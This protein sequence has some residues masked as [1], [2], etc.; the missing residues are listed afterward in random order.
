M[1]NLPRKEAL[2]MLLKIEKDFSYIN[3]EMNEIRKI[4]QYTDQDIRFIGEL[5]NG[6]I[7][8][9]I[10]LDYIISL[11]SSVKLK[12]ISPYVLNVLRIGVYQIIF[13]DKVPDSAAVNECVKL[14]KKSSVYK[15]ASFVNAVLRNVTVDD[16]NNIGTETNED[17]SVKYSFPKW[18]SDRWIKRYGVEFA[19][20]LMS[21]LNS[22]SGI[23]VRRTN[24]ATQAELESM[25]DSEGTSYN[26]VEIAWLPGFD[27]CY[28]IELSKSLDKLPSFL[29]GCFYVQDPAAAIA[30][31]LVQAS[32]DETIIDMCASPGGKSMYISDI[33]QN[34]GKIFSCDI[35][36]QKI[37]LI[38]ENAKKYGCEN[39]VTLI[40]DATV[41]NEKFE[42]VAD[43]VLCDVPCSGFGIIRK[44]P[45]IRYSRVQEDIYS[46]CGMS[47]LILDNASKYLKP[48]GTL[49][50]STCTIEPEE[51]EEVIK[52]FLSTH[53]N[54]S[55]YP[56][57]TEN[58]SFKTF[59]P[60][61]DHTD[62]FFVCRLK[63]NGAV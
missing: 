17:I 6:V 54:F 30:A 57:G 55:L 62:G 9:K 45:D 13:M 3:H 46:L 52:K 20:N 29:K 12:K 15:S 33:M 40:S 16:Y 53:Q 32:K 31:Y 63:K 44:K 1:N 24:K 5:V 51:N 10:T 34:S 37:K 59:Y 21:S 8:R 18:I 25:F 7:K 26:K 47:E 28:K 38:E 56:F 27:R 22:K 60:N 19:V 49:V 42:N 48:G 2:M 41:F 4:G 39:V 35:Y 50:F 61:I 36:P 14:V 58:I 11:H 23:F 43:R